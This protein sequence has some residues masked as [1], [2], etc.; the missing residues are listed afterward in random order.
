MTRYMAVGIAEGFEEAESKEQ[1][2]E[3]WQFIYDNNIHHSLQG[4]FG[5]NLQELINS[6]YINT[7]GQ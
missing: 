7:G 2:I 3:A 1:I 6:G 4:W 5:R